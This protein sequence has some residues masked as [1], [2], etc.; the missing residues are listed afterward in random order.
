MSE[1]K[2]KIQIKA[3]KEIMNTHQRMVGMVY[4]VVFIGCFLVTSISLITREYF[5]LA[6]WLILFLLNFEFEEERVTKF[7]NGDTDE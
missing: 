4:L 1:E 6:V 5:G 3:K 7:L 2:E